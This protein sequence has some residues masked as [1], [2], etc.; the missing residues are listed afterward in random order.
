VLVSKLLVR[1][2]GNSPGNRDD[3]EDDGGISI[4]DP[5]LDLPPGV[6]LPVEDRDSVP[7]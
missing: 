7:A 3:D 4:D 5:V 6:T 2:L 1:Y